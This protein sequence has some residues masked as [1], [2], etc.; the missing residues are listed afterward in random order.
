MAVSDAKNREGMKTMTSLLT[1]PNLFFF[2]LLFLL[3]LNLNNFCLKIPIDM[4]PISKFI[5]FK[6]LS[7]SINFVM[8]S[9]F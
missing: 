7:N 5:K 6:V 4:N 2:L 8:F 3:N 1:S 9:S